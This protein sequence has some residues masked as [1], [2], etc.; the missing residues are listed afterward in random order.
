M[1]K[2]LLLILSFC[3]VYRAG[4]C[5]ST[6]TN[7]NT[8]KDDRYVRRYLLWFNPSRANEINGISISGFIT[9]HLFHSDSLKIRGINVGVEPMWLFAIPYVI[10]GSLASPFYRDRKDAKARIDINYT[11]DSAEALVKISGLN[12]GICGS[13]FIENKT[14]GISINGIGTLGIL[15]NGVAFSF[16]MNLFYKFNGLSVAGLMNDSEK[17]NGIQIAL[18]NYCTDCSGLQIGLWNKMGKRGL[19]FI[20]FNIRKKKQT[21]LKSNP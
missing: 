17:G 19:P 10:V 12:I 15:H 5:Q 21:V 9:P 11:P 20:N 13:T 2:L 18:F 1:N 8:V 14:N 3:F 6:E 4:I 16:G 7:K